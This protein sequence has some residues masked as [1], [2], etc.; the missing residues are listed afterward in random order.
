MQ[1]KKLEKHQIHQL[2]GGSSQWGLGLDTDEEIR[3]FERQQDQDE[4]GQ[5][6]EDDIETLDVEKLL[7][8]KSLNL[9]QK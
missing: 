5:L 4:G 8:D 9:S 3:K 7:A 1:R 2:R 6:T